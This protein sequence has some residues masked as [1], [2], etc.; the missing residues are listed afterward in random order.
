MSDELALI[1]GESSREFAAAVAEQI[2]VPLLRAETVRGYRGTVQ[3]LPV[4]STITIL[5][6][7]G[8]IPR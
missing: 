2:G 1:A 4:D 8:A 5:K 6:R 7:H 3:A